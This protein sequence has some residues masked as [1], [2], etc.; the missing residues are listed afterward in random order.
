MI[1]WVR[2]YDDP[3]RT[4]IITIERFRVE[5]IGQFGDQG[6]IMFWH[7]ELVRRIVCWKEGVEKTMEIAS[8]YETDIAYLH[9]PIWVTWTWP[10]Q[11]MSVRRILDCKLIAEDVVVGHRDSE[12]QR[13]LSTPVGVH[14][15]AV[16][17][18]QIG[19][20]TAASA[21]QSLL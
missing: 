10:P 13:K 14:E 18:S 7:A 20:T 6:F 3:G 16:S 5:M 17:S 12:G 19:I 8:A 9:G 21:N 2:L 11:G 1:A 4:V 15:R